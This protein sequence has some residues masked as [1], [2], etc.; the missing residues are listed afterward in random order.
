[1]SIR[2]NCRKL[3]IQWNTRIEN[4]TKKTQIDN[5]TNKFANGEIDYNNCI[6]QLAALGVTA[7]AL[8]ASSIRF[9]YKNK[10]YTITQKN[11]TTS[12]PTYTLSQLQNS[13]KFSD[14]IIK[15]Y[16]KKQNVSTSGA[17]GAKQNSGN[18]DKYV[19]DTSSG[20]KTISDVEEIAAK[21]YQK[22]MVLTNFL[23]DMNK[24]TQFLICKK[25]VMA[26]K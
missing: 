25:L 20:C 23:N 18:I 16:F 10:T 1:M 5:I 21:Q 7:T 24:Q 19:V 12:T 14:E 11:A 4:D 15:K 2:N 8:S 9:S 6:S 17:A 22:D 3:F 13:Y 26:K